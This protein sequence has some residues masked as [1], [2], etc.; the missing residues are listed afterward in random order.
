M[1]DVLYFEPLII[2]FESLRNKCD[3][4]DYGVRLD[5]DTIVQRRAYR[6]PSGESWKWR[7]HRLARLIE[8]DR[9][10]YAEQDQEILDDIGADDSLIL[11]A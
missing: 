10:I 5:V 1:N 4:P 7:I 3:P 11:R 8:L 6:V 2:E 9:D